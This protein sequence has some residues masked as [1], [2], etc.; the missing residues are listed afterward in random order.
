MRFYD[1]ADVIA[2][3]T[4]I[5]FIE[6]YKILFKSKTKTPQRFMVALIFESKGNKPT[7]FINEIADY[8]K[9]SLTKLIKIVN[10]NL[11]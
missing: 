6:P 3:K 7:I 5:R 11:S 1:G 8:N 2:D 4:N 10:D 9:C